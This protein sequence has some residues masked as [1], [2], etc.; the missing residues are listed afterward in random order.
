MNKVEFIEG[1]IRNG[2]RNITISGIEEEKVID[3]NKKGNKIMLNKEKIKKL[4]IENCTNKKGEI[5]LSD[6]DFGDQDVLLNGI[7]TKGKINNSYQ[8]AELIDNSW[9]KANDYIDN[10]WQ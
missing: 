8:K 10:S 5:D 1:V 3:K 9:Q 2:C 6:L 4:I 7:K